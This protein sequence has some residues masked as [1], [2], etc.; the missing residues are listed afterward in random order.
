MRY[1]S[2]VRFLSYLY[3]FKAYEVFYN[4]TT[5]ESLSIF[6]STSFVLFNEIVITFKGVSICFNMLKSA[7]SGGYVNFGVF[8][9]YGDDALDNSLNMFVKLAYSVQRKDILVKN[10]S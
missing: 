4:V 3:I 1:V 9:L 7:L 5:F 6:F 8:A 10:S 2:K